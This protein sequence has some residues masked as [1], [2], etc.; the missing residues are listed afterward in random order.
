MCIYECVYMCTES[1]ILVFQVMWCCVLMCTGCKLS[2]VTVVY[3]PF[4]YLLKALMCKTL[5][6]AVVHELAF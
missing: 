3:T 4:P 6:T 1:A 2:K 5:G